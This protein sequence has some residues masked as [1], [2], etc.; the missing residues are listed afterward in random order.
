[1]GKLNA[2]DRVTALR[3]AEFDGAMLESDLSERRDNHGCVRRRG[4]KSVAHHQTHLGRV[5]GRVNALNLHGDR[6]VAA[7]AICVATQRDKGDS[8]EYNCLIVPAN[9]SLPHEF[10]ERFAPADPG[11]PAVVVKIVQGKKDEPSYEADSIAPIYF[12]IDS[13]DITGT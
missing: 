9:T 2:A 1:M 8:K 7:H 11:S 12:D 10:E 4:R 5:M 6:P 3:S 13:P